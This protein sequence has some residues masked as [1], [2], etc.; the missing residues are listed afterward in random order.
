[1]VCAAACAAAGAVGAA[2]LL[3]Q[4]IPAELASGDAPQV[5][6]ISAQPYNGS[7]SIASFPIMSEQTQL[8]TRA[9]GVMTAYYCAPG[10]PLA[11]GAPVA[12]VGGQ[13]V[14]ALAT[15]VPLWRDLAVGSTGADVLA[16]QTELVELGYD[17]PMDGRFR[18]STQAAV[19]T[20][21][22][23]GPRTPGVLP[24]SRVVWLPEPSVIPDECPLSVGKDVS[25]GSVIAGLGGSLV[26]LELVT[27]PETGQWVADFDRTAGSVLADGVVNDPAIIAAIA[28]SP[29]LEM[30]LAPGGFDTI[31]LNLRLAEPIIVASVPSSAVEATGQGVGCVWSDDAARRVTIIGSSLGQT[32]VS[33]EGAQLPPDVYIRFPAGQRCE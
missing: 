22:G 24:L 15:E 6:A 14:V 25:P 3:A 23:E 31:D 5:I 18:A 30:A 10:E 9:F 4:P 20:L 12:A 21:L 7:R 2:V 13:S 27:P 32:L 19:R 1:L 33:F 17:V 29:W 28:A 8:I 11:S 26:A 16:L